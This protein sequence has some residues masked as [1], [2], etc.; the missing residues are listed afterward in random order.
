[1]SLLATRACTDRHSMPIPDTKKRHIS[2]QSY[3]PLVYLGVG[4]TVLDMINGE[5]PLAKQL[6]RKGCVMQ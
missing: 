1:M 4:G 3:Y 2:L 5:T 6:F